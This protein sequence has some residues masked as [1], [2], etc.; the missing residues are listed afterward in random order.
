MNS[1]KGQV[2]PLVLIALAFGTLMVG[3]SL[4]YISTGIVNSQ[5][6]EEL[7]T[8]QYALDAGV[9]YALWRLMYEDGFRDSVTEDNP[10][11]PFPVS[12]NGM[13]VSVAVEL[14]PVGTEGPQSE[15]IRVV[16][17][18]VPDPG[19]TP[20]GEPTTF[21]YTIIV[22]NVGT[23]TVHLEQ[24]GDLLP[25]GLAYVAGSAGLYPDNISLAEPGIEGMGEHQE[26]LWDFGTSLP[27]VSSGETATQTF[28]A[29]ASQWG[30]YN[31]A[32]VVAGPESIGLVSS[33]SGDRY[34]IAAQAGGQ[35]A[36][37]A[38]VA[39]EAGQLIVLS[40]QIE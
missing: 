34:D 19:S 40:W 24:I 38:T 35:L 28:Q 10:P 15:R 12:V 25:Q 6:S 36:L 32:W 5:I 14:A 9:E 26:L 29:V 4:K 13:E 37:R 11:D 16:Y 7:L 2:L 23:S 1:E 33:A 3:P 20:Q 31:E 27:E 8:E 21:V 17:G 30:S 39:F 22:D 18:V